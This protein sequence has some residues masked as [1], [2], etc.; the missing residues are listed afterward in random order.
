MR[1][2][3]NGNDE[4]ERTF[5]YKEIAKRI[6]NYIKADQLFLEGE[7]EQYPE[8]KKDKDERKAAYE[9]FEQF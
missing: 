6:C 8:W 2:A 5:S 1:G 9:A 7:K 3:N 4:L